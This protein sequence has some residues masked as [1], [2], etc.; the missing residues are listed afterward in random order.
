E[1]E[2]ERKKRTA[3]PLKTVVTV[4]Q[5]SLP[6]LLASP[7]AYISIDVEPS[8]AKSPEYSKE[9]IVAEVEEK[10]NSMP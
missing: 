1:K 10:Q 9:A 2:E 8:V 4:E 3:V 7:P 5:I 6:G